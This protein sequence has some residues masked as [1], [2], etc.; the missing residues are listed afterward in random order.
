MIMSLFRGLKVAQVDA[1]GAAA[2]AGLQADDILQVNT[3]I[4]FKIN[5]CNCLFVENQRCRN[6]RSSSISQLL[7]IY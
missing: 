1:R 4:Y 6:L 2:Q 7:V 3:I 5:L